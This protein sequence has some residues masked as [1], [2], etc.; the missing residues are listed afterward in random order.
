M[1]E[2]PVAVFDTF[3]NIRIM[4]VSY[5]VQ[6]TNDQ[7]VFWWSEFVQQVTVLFGKEQDSFLSEEGGDSRPYGRVSG[8]YLVPLQTQIN[9]FNP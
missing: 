2:L 4:L 1:R 9:I 3:S 7:E 6:Q 5:Q 8:I